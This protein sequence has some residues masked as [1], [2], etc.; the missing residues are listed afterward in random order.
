MERFVTHPH[1]FQPCPHYQS[2]KQCWSLPDAYLNKM[3]S[4]HF[5]GTTTWVVMSGNKE[6]GLNIVIEHYFTPSPQRNKTRWLGWGTPIQTNTHKHARAQTKVKL[7]QMFGT[8]FKLF[9]FKRNIPGWLIRFLISIPGLLTCV[10]KVT[11]KYSFNAFI[12]QEEKWQK[13]YFYSDRLV[14][15]CLCDY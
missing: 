4:L 12:K 3:S 7:K 15:V 10:N 14:C 11:P 1:C 6:R 9:S 13:I 8:I 5:S 2:Y